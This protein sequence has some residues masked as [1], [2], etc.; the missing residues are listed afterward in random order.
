MNDKQLIKSLREKVP[1]VSTPP[2]L[3]SRILAASR[4][5]EL[6]QEKSLLPRLL[7]IAIALPV[8]ALALGALLLFPV[9]DDQ[10][11]KRAVTELPEFEPPLS[12]AAIQQPVRREYEG[13]K[14]DARR[15]MDLFRNT[16]PSIPIVLKKN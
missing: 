13:F 11:K 9:P 1:P 3:E 2:G 10:P 15:T 12:T 8:T 5:A 16:I 6:S 7:P 4:R 14:S